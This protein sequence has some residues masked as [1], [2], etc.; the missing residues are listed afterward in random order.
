MKEWAQ[1]NC[2]SGGMPQQMAAKFWPN[3]G[4]LWRY[5]YA[6]GALGLAIDDRL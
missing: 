5:E 4:Q 1:P 3:R 6:P 2:K